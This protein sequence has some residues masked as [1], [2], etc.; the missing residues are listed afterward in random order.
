MDKLYVFSIL[1]GISEDVNTYNEYF[2]TSQELLKYMSDHIMSAE[3]YNDED[4]SYINEDDVDFK[5]AKP[6]DDPFKYMQEYID[7]KDKKGK[8]DDETRYSI[9]ILDLTKDEVYAT[10]GMDFYS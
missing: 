10:Q 8:I 2:K 9:T 6:T 5:R 3:S 4:D 7:Y 1:N